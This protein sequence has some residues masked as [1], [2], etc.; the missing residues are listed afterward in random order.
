[1]LKDEI[2][3]I[4]KPS[5][6]DEKTMDMFIKKLLEVSS[7]FKEIQPMLCGSVAK[8]TW[9]K[10]K[11]EVDFF[12]L[13]PHNTS[14]ERLRKKGLEIAK[15]II[16]ELKGRFVIAYAEHPYLRGNIRFM[17]RDY[18][19]DIV[20]AY[21]I[22][23]PEKIKSA[24][25]RTPHHVLFIKENLKNH[26][27]VRL[28]KQFCLANNVYGADVKT[29]GFSG[30]LCELLILKFEDFYNL[31]KEAT[32]WRA[33]T[34]ID[35]ERSLQ[36]FKSP[37]VVIDPVDRNR[38]V[39]AA[40]SEEA[41]YKFVAAC[42]EYVNKPSKESFFK[43]K[44]KPLSSKE[45]S[46]ILRKR[47]TKWFIIKFKRP[48]VLDDVLYPQMRRFANSIE[49]I[50]I[51]NDFHVL[52]KDFWCNG[53][54]IFLLE[55]ETWHL[56]K[57]IKNIGPN[58]FS[59][60]AEEFLKHY[61]DKKIFTEGENW[62]VELEREF[63]EVSQLL[64]NLIRKSK[65]ELLEKGIPTKIAPSLRKAKLSEEFLKEYKHFP[66]DFKVFLRGFFEKDFDIV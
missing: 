50:L 44:E 1:M 7:K 17:K 15:S 30:Y 47:E 51:Q 39:A 57:T 32:K 62:V 27:D 31:M 12:L 49:K 59:K 9:L 66:L 64:R 34:A 55:M 29:Q 5:K 33:G 37:L 36:K 3:G 43:K 61:N 60:H 42:K 16:K 11:H 24:V 23:D 56:P 6:T 10:E 35:A 21:D 41:F 25:D 65:K 46:K 13:F 14:R 26:D 19:I 40:V 58:I 2:L 28:L 53:G 18:K 45:L 4:I 48:K 63:T 8:G 38:N 20:P 54:C 22:A 52:R